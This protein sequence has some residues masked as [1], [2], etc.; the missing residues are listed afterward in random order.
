M[1]PLQF[2]LE[3]RFPVLVQGVQTGL[4][5]AAALLYLLFGERR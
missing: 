1:H 4:Q 2:R 3:A 5:V